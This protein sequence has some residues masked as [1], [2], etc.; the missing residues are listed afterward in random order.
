MKKQTLGL[1]A[2]VILIC[3]LFVGCKSLFSGCG[4][5]SHKDDTSRCTICGS[6]RVVYSSGTYGYCARHYT[7]MKHNR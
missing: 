6:R 1:V 2:L 7:D 5:P 4:N 3:V